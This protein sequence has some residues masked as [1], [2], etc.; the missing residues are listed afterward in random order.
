[1]LPDN[2]SKALLPSVG[3]IFGMA[4]KRANDLLQACGLMIQRGKKLRMSHDSWTALRSEYGVDIE[5]ETVSHSK[6][7]GNKV[8]LIRVGS[9]KD[10]GRFNAKDLVKK[11]SE[12]TYRVPRMRFTA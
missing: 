11:M 9:F 5:V 12:E 10:E 4:D 2:K 1:M 7:I 6:L 3:D 8:I